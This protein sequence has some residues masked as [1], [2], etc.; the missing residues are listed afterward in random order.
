VTPPPAAPVPPTLTGVPLPG[1]VLLVVP[2]QPGP[3][4]LTA[5]H[6]AVRPLLDL[7]AER[8]LLANR[9]LLTDRNPLTDRDPLATRPDPAADRSKL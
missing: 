6:A 1:G 4:D 3:D 2:A 7:L 9:D 5:I 8:G